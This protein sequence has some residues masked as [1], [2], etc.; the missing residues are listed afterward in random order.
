MRDNAIATGIIAGIVGVLW[1]LTIT[2]AA[3]C[4]IWAQ[5]N[6]S[7][8]YPALVLVHSVTG[9]ICLILTMLSI[10]FGLASRR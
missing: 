8:C 2:G 10:V 9:P 6:G 7:T 3:N 1:A 4:G 5:L